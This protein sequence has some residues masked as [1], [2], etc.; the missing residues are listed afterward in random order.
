MAITGRSRCRTLNKSRGI[1]S[2]AAY[3]SPGSMS[4]FDLHPN[5]WEHGG[6]SSKNTHPTK[7]H[8]YQNRRGFFY[9]CLLNPNRKISAILNLLQRIPQREFPPDLHFLSSGEVNLWHVFP[10]GAYHHTHN[11]I[12][13]RFELE[14][15]V[16]FPTFIF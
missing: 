12:E 13:K 14:V 1:W 11:P 8:Y 2:L 4:I 9:P 10:T 7:N 15:L 3:N 5:R 6:H 16:S